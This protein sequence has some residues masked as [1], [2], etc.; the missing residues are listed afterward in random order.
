MA[1]SAEPRFPATV[2]MIPG[3]ALAVGAGLDVGRCVGA[4]GY[5][6]LIDTGVTE[7]A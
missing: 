1:T 4:V 3:N 2:L 5:T 7:G 6:D